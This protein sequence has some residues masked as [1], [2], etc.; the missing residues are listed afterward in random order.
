MKHGL[1]R[2]PDF[3]EYS[4]IFCVLQKLPSDHLVQ[5]LPKGLRNYAS[6]SLSREKKRVDQFS[7]V[8]TRRKLVA[9]I[10][11]V[12][13][14]FNVSLHRPVLRTRQGLQSFLL[15][16]EGP[17]WLR[18]QNGGSLSISITQMILFHLVLTGNIGG[19]VFEETHP[20]Y[21]QKSL[22]ELRWTEHFGTWGPDLTTQIFAVPSS[23]AV[24]TSRKIVSCYIW[25]SCIIWLWSKK[26]WY[27]HE[28]Q[29][30]AIKLMANNLI[31]AGANGREPVCCR[32]KRMQ[33][34]QLLCGL[35][36]AKPPAEHVR[37]T[38]KSLVLVTK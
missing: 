31:R 13:I 37:I 1:E 29:S 25:G 38:R 28:S 8:E 23:E 27:P 19:S 10:S 32:A 11:W 22:S 14:P 26:C 15:L 36:W 3:F 6:A 7:G 17:N 21:F 20:E 12:S 24:T 30:M 2:K 18:L 16:P 5:R 35:A 9:T 4:G 33:N 34:K